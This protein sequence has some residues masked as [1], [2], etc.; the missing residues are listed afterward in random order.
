MGSTVFGAMVGLPGAG[1]PGLV[2]GVKVFPVGNN[3]GIVVGI[4]RIVGDV[5]GDDGSC[6]E[7]G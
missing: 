4:G 6:E 1:V 2:V 5:V 3:V 7:T